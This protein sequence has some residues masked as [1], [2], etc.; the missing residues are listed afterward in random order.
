LPTP[1]V[2]R[3]G[4]PVQLVVPEAPRAY[5][6]VS[7]AED[8]AVQFIHQARFVT[9]WNFGEAQLGGVKRDDGEASGVDGGEG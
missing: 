4:Q 6:R 1:R 5:H 2:R 9:E 8:I 7:I 3:R